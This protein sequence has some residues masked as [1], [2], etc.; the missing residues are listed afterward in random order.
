MVQPIS[1]SL[2]RSSPQEHLEWVVD[3]ALR[4]ETSSSRVD[5]L[6]TF[7]IGSCIDVVPD[8]H[9]STR[10]RTGVSFV[11]GSFQVWRLSVNILQVPT[12]TLV[13]TSRRELSGSARLKTEPFLRLSCFFLSI[14]FFFGPPPLPLAF[15]QDSFPFTS[16]PFGMSWTDLFRPNR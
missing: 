1:T 16:R 14:F 11:A 10:F 15:L 4:R 9:R 8:P 7:P 2:D 6:Q 5:T 12:L 3:L 13:A